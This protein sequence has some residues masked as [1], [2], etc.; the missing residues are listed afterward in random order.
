[1]TSKKNSVINQET[2]IITKKDIMKMFWRSFTIQFSWHYER[3][4]HM[5]FE[6][7]MIPTLKKLYKDD[8]EQLKLA[9]QRHME[10]FN[11]N[12]YISTFIGGVTMAME[13]M[14]VKDK[15]FDTSSINAVKAA[16]MGPLAGIGDSLFLGTLRILAV[17]IGTSLAMQ[18]SIL[19]PILFLLVFNVPAMLVRYIGAFK[20]YEIGANYLNKIQESGLMEKFMYAA[21]IIGVM[22]IG[23]M[24]NE[25]VVASTPLTIGTGDGAVAIQG[26][27]DGLMPG[28]LSLCA[29]GIYYKLLNKK[30]NVIILLL[31]TVVA[32]ILCSWAGILG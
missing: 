9:M 1:M 3:Q 14:N 27:L 7:M 28:L 31:G 26:V 24:T 16:L 20:G 13:E 25:L 18:G 29:L 32:G 4:M 10:F 23:G 19:G 5:G 22:V 21:A 11:T 17:G 12:M 15:N 8:P 6:Y 30:V 2:G